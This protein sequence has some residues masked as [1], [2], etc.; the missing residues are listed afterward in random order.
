M[1]PVLAVV[2]MANGGLSYIISTAWTF[3]SGFWSRNFTSELMSKKP[4]G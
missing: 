3:L 1:M 4:I 2:A